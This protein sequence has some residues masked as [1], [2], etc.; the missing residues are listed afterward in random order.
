MIELEYTELKKQIKDELKAELEAEQEVEIKD[1]DTN[2]QN[3]G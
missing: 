1:K 2:N 3:K